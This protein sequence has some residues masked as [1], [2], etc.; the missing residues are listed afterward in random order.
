MIH[1]KLVKGGY[2]S[3]SEVKKMDA[4][5]V[6]QALAYENFLIDYENAI[7]DLNEVDK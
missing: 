5:E 3:L 1:I 4:R 2:G 7:Y 6:I